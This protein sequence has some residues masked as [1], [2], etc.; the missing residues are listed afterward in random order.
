MVT[1]PSSGIG[2]EVALALGNLGFHV[3]AAGRSPQRVGVVV[4]QIRAGG[5]S[6]EVLVLDLASLQSVGEAARQIGDRPVDV[7]INNAGVGVPRGLTREGFQLQF[8]INHLGHF[9]L[10]RELRGNLV[11]GARIIQVS[12]EYHR[13]AS[14][15]DFDLVRR[16]ARRFKGLEA[17]ASSKLANI[18]F[19]RELARRE[20]QWHA[21]AVHPGLVDTGIFPSWAMIF[22]RRNA[23]TPAE[24]A[25]TI[26]WA[27]TAPELEKASGGYY[28]RRQ[29][30]VPSEVALDDALA[31]ELWRRSEE[32]CAPGGA[33]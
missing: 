15:I 22:I 18:L 19:I 11:P 24:G 25:D 26:V 7:L 23:L 33:G 9:M 16:P 8:G 31:A 27:A 21:F 5:G 4:D 1:G 30:R 29:E 2:R 14:G 10:T 13:R 32:W 17:Y 20:P 28:S 12:S 3:I 6:A